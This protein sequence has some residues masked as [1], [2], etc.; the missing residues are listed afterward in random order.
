MILLFIFSWGA[1]LAINTYYRVGAR[2]A[3][4]NCVNGGMTLIPN[5]LVDV[6]GT[7]VVNPLKARLIIEH[8]FRW[9]LYFDFV[10]RTFGIAKY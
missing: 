10:H 3:W 5:S 2:F 4:H 8:Y 7:L 9:D 6:V 1:F